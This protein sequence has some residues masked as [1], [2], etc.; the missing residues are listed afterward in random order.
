[1]KHIA[2]AFLLLIVLLA[3]GGGEQQTQETAERPEESIQNET[4]DSG[5][6]SDIK[7]VKRP[8]TL[9]A[10]KFPSAA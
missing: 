8:T 1:M 7:E 6:N 10:S 3:C 9:A 4:L 5:A 2:I